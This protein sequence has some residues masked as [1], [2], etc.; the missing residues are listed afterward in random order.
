M[1]V[2][3]IDTPP[4]LAEKFSALGIQAVTYAHPP[5][6]TVEEGK[7]FKHKI[8]GGHTKNLFLKDKKGQLWLITA[9]WDTAIDLKSLP[10][11]IGCDRVSF[12]SAERMEAA[13]GVT[14]GSV[15]PLALMN[16][17]QKT[18]KPVF[19]SR[20]MDCGLVNCHP[21]KNDKTTGLSPQDLLKFIKGLGYNPLIID[22]GAV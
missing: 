17:L 15:T 16:D 5:V 11:K 6:F 20:L 9:L 12:G 22:F 8:P 19:D 1:E 18:V 4:P 10:D 21:L 14:P 2:T 3:V 7:D 13:I